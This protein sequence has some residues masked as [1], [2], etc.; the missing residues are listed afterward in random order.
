MTTT[1]LEL[2]QLIEELKAR[3]VKLEKLTERVYWTDL[4][5]HDAVS[6]FKHDEDF[7]PLL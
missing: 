2:N 5:L 7:L 1:I 6:V 4:K 3:Y